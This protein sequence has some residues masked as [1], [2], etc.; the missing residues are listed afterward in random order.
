MVR[1]Q[2]VAHGRRLASLGPALVPL[3][4]DAVRPALWPLAAAL[5]ALCGYAVV[6]FGLPDSPP[7]P[8]AEWKPSPCRVLP[9][10]FRR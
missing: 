7:P 5:W 10:D 1:G 9:E 4:E 6:R 2:D 3:V 8:A